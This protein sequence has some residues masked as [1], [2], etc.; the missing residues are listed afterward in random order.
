M[1]FSNGITTVHTHVLHKLSC[2]LIVYAK[3]LFGVQ[4]RRKHLST[5]YA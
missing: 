2:I 1:P 3:I 4:H 5:H